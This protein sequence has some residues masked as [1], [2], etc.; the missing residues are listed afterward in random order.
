MQVK[1]FKSNKNIPF[2]EPG[3][4]LLDSFKI[5]FDLMTDFIDRINTIPGLISL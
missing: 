3:L 4:P 1:K 2:F 5:L